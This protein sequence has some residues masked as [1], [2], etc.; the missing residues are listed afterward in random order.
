M[1]PLDGGLLPGVAEAVFYQ[2]A[3]RLG[4]ARNAPRKPEI[5]DLLDQ[6]TVHGHADALHFL[7]WVCSHG[8][9]YALRTNGS[10]WSV[11][12]DDIQLHLCTFI[13]CYPQICRGDNFVGEARNNFWGKRKDGRK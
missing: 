13:L 6:P 4:A 3:D 12:T 10:K 5:I 9:D 11:H 1:R 7:D 2:P 8:A